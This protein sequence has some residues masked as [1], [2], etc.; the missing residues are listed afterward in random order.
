MFLENE[1]F[2]SATRVTEET[3]NS[4]A[5]LSSLINNNS[6]QIINQITVQRAPL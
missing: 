5:Q 6:F 4:T 3:Q 2:I 1:N